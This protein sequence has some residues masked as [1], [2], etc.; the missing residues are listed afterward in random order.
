[1]SA[2]ALEQ[3]PAVWVAFFGTLVTVV[4][5]CS[6]HA[7][8]QR[9]FK[10]ETLAPHNEV[11][12]V[13]L[14]VIGTLYAVILGFVV[15]VAWQSFTTASDVCGNEANA[16][17]YVYRLARG[18]PQPAHDN[19]RHDIAHYA[20]SVLTIE[21]PRMVTGGK[22]DRSTGDLA[23][24]I[25]KEVVSFQPAT[26]SATNL[27]AAMLSALGEF[28]NDRR[29]RLTYLESRIPQILWG[30][31]IF[32]ALVL[33]GITFLIG[34]QNRAVQL[35]MTAA[36]SATIALSLVTIFELDSP[37]EGATHIE[38]VAWEIFAGQTAAAP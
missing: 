5:A 7:L 29:T 25:A 22:S 27:Q 9:I 2:A 1:V 19:I 13:I 37:L 34:L 15:V 35:I 3:V 4:V 18:L 21:W 14:T 8:V 23:R 11:A 30:V 17:A 24:Q 12:G 32:G 16:L 33:L 6:L 10:H 31:L 38:P 26:T 20:Q 28:L 36:L